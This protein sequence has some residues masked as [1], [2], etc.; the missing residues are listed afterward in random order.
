MPCVT[1]I[2]GAQRAAELLGVH[3]WNLSISHTDEYAIASA[4]ATA[5]RCEVLGF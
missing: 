3:R 4:I 1:L 2:E 5:T